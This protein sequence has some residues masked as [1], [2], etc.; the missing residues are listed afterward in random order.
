MP[1]TKVISNFKGEEIVVIFCKKE[2]QKT[3]QTEFRIAKAIKRKSDR[4][5]AKWK[6]YDNSFNIFF[7]P[8]DHSGANKNLGFDLSNSAAEVNLKEATDIDISALALK[9]RLFLLILVS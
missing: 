1:W 4:L 2:L 7:K 3:S 9:S 6:S 8:Y 5:Y